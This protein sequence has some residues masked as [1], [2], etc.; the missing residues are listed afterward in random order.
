MVFTSRCHFY[1]E[2]R[3]EVVFVKD[4]FNNLGQQTP[5]DN[6]VSKTFLGLDSNRKNEF[7]LFIIRAEIARLSV[8]G[9]LQKEEE[10]GTILF[11]CFFRLQV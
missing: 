8:P 11:T 6:P 10:T 2:P 4:L 3:S 7:W 5:H 1:I 9:S